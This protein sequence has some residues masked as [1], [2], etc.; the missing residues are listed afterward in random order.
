M[1]KFRET[2]PAAAC[3][4]ISL[5]SRGCAVRATVTRV[6]V[7]TT[8]ATTSKAFRNVNVKYPVNC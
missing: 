2:L 3:S 8:L 1:L 4:R 7:M 6:T 5:S